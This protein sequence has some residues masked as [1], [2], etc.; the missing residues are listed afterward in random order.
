MRGL[1]MIREVTVGGTVG[2]STRRRGRVGRMVGSGTVSGRARGS[3]CGVVV[4]AGAGSG[5]FFDAFATARIGSSG[6]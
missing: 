5:R 1:Y 6:H 4:A 2:Q 3:L